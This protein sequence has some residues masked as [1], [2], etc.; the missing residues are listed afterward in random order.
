MYDFFYNFYKKPL[1]FDLF[2]RN[3]N[4]NAPPVPVSQEITSQ[5]GEE[6]TDQTGIEL[7]SN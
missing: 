3:N 1:A 7:I 5:T 2:T 4:G 6:M